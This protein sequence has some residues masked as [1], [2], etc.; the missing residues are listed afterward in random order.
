MADSIKKQILARILA[1]L[2]AEILSQTNPTPVGKVRQVKREMDLLKWSEALPALMLYDGD[3]EIVSEDDTGVTLQFPIMLKLCWSD[4]RDLS[5]K[6]DELV[7]EIQRVM[8]SDQ[9]LAGLVNWIKGGEE[10][11]FLNEIGKPEGGA[12]VHY[13]V[14]YRRRRGNPYQSY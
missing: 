4:H 7:P 12:L 2:T 14:E 1:A 5:T 13:L 9:Q 10:E 3:E 8:E 6:K 11:P